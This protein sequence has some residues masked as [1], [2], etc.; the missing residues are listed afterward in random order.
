LVTKEEELEQEARIALLNHYSS[1][2]SNQVTNC[3]TIA[4]IF[5]AFVTAIEPLRTLFGDGN[6]SWLFGLSDKVL[7]DIFI[8]FILSALMTVGVHTLLRLF[9]WGELAS[10]ILTCKMASQTRAANRWDQIAKQ[11]KYV[12]SK[13]QEKTEKWGYSANESPDSISTYMNRLSL[14]CWDIYNALYL[15]KSEEPY[16]RRRISLRFARWKEAIIAGLVSFVII[17]CIILFAA[18]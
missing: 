8:A 10:L 18:L 7:C 14:G 9:Y 2:S 5:F 6:I 4:L 13:V 11:S 3:L 17:I 16:H 15:T 12:K 1:K